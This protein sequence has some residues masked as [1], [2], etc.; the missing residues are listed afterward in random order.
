[1]VENEQEVREEE[2]KL[3]E[4]MHYFIERTTQSGLLMNCSLSSTEGGGETWY[5]PYIWADSGLSS[6][7]LVLCPTYLI[8]LDKMDVSTTPENPVKERRILDS[9]LKRNLAKTRKYIKSLASDLIPNPQL[10]ALDISIECPADSSDYTTIFEFGLGNLSEPCRI[11]TPPKQKN[12]KNKEEFEERLNTWEIFYSP[13]IRKYG[14]KFREIM[15]LGKEFTQYE[16]G[17]LVKVE[18]CSAFDVDS[19]GLDSAKRVIDLGF[20]ICQ[21]EELDDFLNRVSVY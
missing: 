14:S 16:N 8:D 19:L 21:D 2:S 15:H 12:Y 5:H 3:E 9:I 10:E 18:N 4:I 11:H 20:K 1:M 13:V 17:A 7:R 6:L